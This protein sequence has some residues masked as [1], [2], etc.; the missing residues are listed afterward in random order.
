M[1]T[2]Q[3]ETPVLNVEARVKNRT[4][5]QDVILALVT[6]WKMK[7]PVTRAVSLHFES[8]ANS[9]G[10]VFPTKKYAATGDWSVS[11]AGFFNRNTVSVTQGTQTGFGDGADVILDFIAAKFASVGYPSCTGI[12]CDFETGA[13]MGADLQKFSCTLDGY[14]VPPAFGTVT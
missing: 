6:E 4:S 8:P 9:H 2:S 12:M 10:A 1:P 5:G 3:T 13:T 7:K 14:G 11:I